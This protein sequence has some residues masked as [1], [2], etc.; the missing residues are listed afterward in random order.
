MTR[1]YKITNQDRGT[2]WKVGAIITPVEP[3]FNAV[4]GDRAFTDAR[5]PGATIHAHKT[6]CVPCD[7][8]GRYL[9]SDHAAGERASHVS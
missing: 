6:E 5:H 7:K 2:A 9:E 8:H 4:T 3:F 1:F